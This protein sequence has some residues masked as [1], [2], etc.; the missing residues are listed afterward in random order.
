MMIIDQDR[1]VM[2]KCCASGCH[3][4]LLFHRFYFCL[5]HIQSDQKIPFD[6]DK[7]HN[8]WIPLGITF[9]LL[10]MSW[11]LYVIN[12]TNFAADS[13]VISQGR[14]E[15]SFARCSQ[16]R[17][18]QPML[19]SV[20]YTYHT[21]IKLYKSE[22]NNQSQFIR[23]TFTFTLILLERA[24]GEEHD[25]IHLTRQYKVMIKIRELSRKLIYLFCGR[26]KS[27]S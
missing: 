11:C 14:P 19:S 27:V 7:D 4:L 12:M 8:R 15:L 17:P 22:W 26:S 23:T 3:V 16:R 10:V 9:I 20:I 1:E 25:L 24:R 21:T 18:V 5:L 13:Q 6:M 2:Q